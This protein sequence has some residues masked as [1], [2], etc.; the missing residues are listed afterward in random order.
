LCILLI[1]IAAQNCIVN[2]CFGWLTADFVAKCAGIS[3]NELDPPRK[4]ALPAQRQSELMK[5][6]EVKG[7]MS[8]SDI[9]AYFGVSEDTVR[10][11]L[12]ALAQRGALTRT[13][14]GAVTVTTLVHRDS[15]FLQRLNTRTAEKQRIAKAAAALIS[16]GETLLING[17]STTRLFAAE[18]NQQYLTVVTNNL[19]VP[20]VLPTEVIR[21]VYVMGG[22]LRPEAQV[23]IGPIVASGIQ[24]SVDSAIIG[25][26]GVTAREGLTTTVLEEASM[27]A[28][29]MAAA[30]RTIVL[31]DSSKLGKHSF[32]QIAGL[33]AMQ[34]LV[35]DADPAEELAAA[36]KE[37][38]VQLVVA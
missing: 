20:G 38:G 22:Q 8:V 31:A 23:T 1:Q 2:A 27:I 34:I 35:T 6:L 3:M 17:G 11:D 7:Q 4:P 37:A 14:G 13:H 21:D 9:S 29:M 12:D 15:P 16:D 26:G 32:A 25:V 30:R 24:I 19:S 5:L 28:A 36:L 18:L 10:R 33:S